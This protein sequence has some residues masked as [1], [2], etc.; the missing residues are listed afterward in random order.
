MATITADNVTI[1]PHKPDDVKVLMEF[2]DENQWDLSTYDHEAYS[3]IDP[4]YLLVAADDSD[5]PVG[6]FALS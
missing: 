6:K 4:N 3:R 5:K 2:S 1:R